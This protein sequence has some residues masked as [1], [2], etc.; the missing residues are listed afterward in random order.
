MKRVVLLTVMG[1]IEMRGAESEY[2]D[3]VLATL[4]CCLQ[5]SKLPDC[6]SDHLENSS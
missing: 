6:N 5:R 2:L 3:S 4:R 1:G